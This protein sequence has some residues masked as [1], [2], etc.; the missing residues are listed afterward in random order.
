MY[1][2]PEAP[3]PPKADQLQLADPPPPYGPYG[4][5]PEGEPPEPLTVGLP[6]CPPDAPRFPKTVVPPLLPAAPPDP[7]E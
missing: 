3:A 7:M 1:M 2:A 5:V 4:Y 6:A